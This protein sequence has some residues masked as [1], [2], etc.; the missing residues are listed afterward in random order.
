LGYSA[1]SYIICS[2]T[3][4]KTVS[5]AGVVTTLLIEHSSE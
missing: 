4:L 1:R 2:E 3:V 5:G